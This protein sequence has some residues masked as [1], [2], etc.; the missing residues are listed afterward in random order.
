MVSWEESLEERK[1]KIAAIECCCVSRTALQLQ[2][3][4]QLQ[5]AAEGLSRAGEGSACAV[6]DSRSWKDGTR[7]R[8]LRED[9]HVRRTPQTHAAEN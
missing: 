9:C 3:T 1:G 6:R 5:L 8:W 2:L 4:L 7:I